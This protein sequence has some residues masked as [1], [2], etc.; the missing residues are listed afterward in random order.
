MCCSSEDYVVSLLF[1]VRNLCYMVSRREKIRRHL[2]V[3]KEQI[4][5]R[6]DAL[7]ADPNQRFG[8]RETAVICRAH[9]LQDNIYDCHNRILELAKAEDPELN[10][11]DID[12][13]L[14]HVKIRKDTGLSRIRRDS[15]LQGE[16]PSKR[17]RQP[18]GTTVDKK[19]KQKEKELKYKMHNVFQRRNGLREREPEAKAGKAGAETEEETKPAAEEVAVTVDDKEQPSKTSEAPVKEELEAGPETEGL[20]DKTSVEGGQGAE[21]DGKATRGKSADETETREK[22]NKKK[23]AEAE[24]GGKGK[25]KEEE[26]VETGGKSAKRGGP[27]RG[28]VGKRR[29]GGESEMGGKDG[30][31]KS[32]GEVESG[33]KVTRKKQSEETDTAKQEA[34]PDIKSEPSSGEQCTDNSVV[35]DTE[36]NGQV[37]EGRRESRRLAADGKAAQPEQPSHKTAASPKKERAA[38]EKQSPR[39]A[40]PAPVESAPATLRPLEPNSPHLKERNTPPLRDLRR[41]KVKN[42]K[43]SKSET[44]ITKNNRRHSSHVNKPVKLPRTERRRRKSELNGIIP[45]S[46]LVVSES[47]KMKVQRRLLK[48]DKR[49]KQLNGNPRKLELLYRSRRSQE[50]IPAHSLRATGLYVDPESASEGGSARSSRR[51]S[52]SRDMDLSLP[53]RGLTDADISG[54]GIKR[55]KMESDIESTTSE[56]PLQSID[57]DRSLRSSRSATPDPEYALRGAH[58]DILL[59]HAARELR[60]QQDMTQHVLNPGE[61]H[62]PIVSLEEDMSDFL[63]SGSDASGYS[64]R[65]SRQRASDNLDTLSVESGASGSSRYSTRRSA[66]RWSQGLGLIKR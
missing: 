56:P 24:T 62:D 42:T 20:E 16:E 7:L 54:I 5:W 28:K 57:G 32:G 35:A 38:V 29:T 2:Y 21:V 55:R 45:D 31:K 9:V 50:N 63:D 11:A 36:D 1:Q 10:L 51:N 19:D 64:T 4:F 6:Q 13:D 49:I 60:L 25:K 61:L 58:H 66:S 17:D 33:G 44:G 34:K 43:K 37:R 15:V 18:S 52:V 41:L 26:D 3:L 14:E 59:D 8:S 46:Q 23:H 27:G 47:L 48:A 39:S 40:D 65:L 30:K 22:T 53:K 12:H